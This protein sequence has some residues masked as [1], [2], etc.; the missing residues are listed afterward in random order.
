[1]C[2]YRCSAVTRT[3]KIGFC[4]TTT[5]CIR[6]SI[7]ITIDEIPFGFDSI[8]FLSNID[9]IHFC[10]LE[11]VHFEFS[12]EVHKKPQ[13]QWNN[14]TFYNFCL[15]VFCHM[16][17]NSIK[18]KINALTKIRTEATH[19]ENELIKTIAWNYFLK[20]FSGISSKQL[21]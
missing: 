12:I 14:F 11:Q 13:Q 16:R 18:M 10:L 9:H 6:L 4:S 1:M 3:N 2:D 21:N 19:S 8:F 20:C 17:Q 15:A 7:I 5:C